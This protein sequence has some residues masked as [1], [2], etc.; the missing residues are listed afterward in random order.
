MQDRLHGVKES[1]TEDDSCADLIFRTATGDLSKVASE[2]RGDPVSEIEV[3]QRWFV[4]DDR[5]GVIVLQ[6]LA[7]SEEAAESYVRGSR[8]IR[9]NQTIAERAQMLANLVNHLFW[10]GPHWLHHVAQSDQS[11][12]TSCATT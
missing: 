1:C 12:T 4:H 3:F 9:S 7:A 2:C 6:L 5:G 11:S 10:K 8:M